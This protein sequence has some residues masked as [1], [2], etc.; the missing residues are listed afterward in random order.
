MCNF[1]N[2]TYWAFSKAGF[3]TLHVCVFF[4]KT[5]TFFQK[6][7]K[8]MPISF[9]LEDNLSLYQYPS[10]DSTSMSDHQGFHWMLSYRVKPGCVSF[11]WVAG[12]KIWMGLR[13]LD[14]YDV[15]RYTYYLFK[16]KLQTNILFTMGNFQWVID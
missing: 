15:K 1:Y 12:L 16:K 14:L 3:S 7:K 10:V 11:I 8:K 13:R 4:S 5:L 9:L 6:K 2:Y